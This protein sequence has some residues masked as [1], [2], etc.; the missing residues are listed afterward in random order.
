M[1]WRRLWNSV[2]LRRGLHSVPFNEFGVQAWWDS[3]DNNEIARRYNPLFKGSKINECSTV[4]SA[5]FDNTRQE[6]I[7]NNHVEAHRWIESSPIF[8]ALLTCER[9]GLLNVSRSS[10]S[11]H[12][13]NDLLGYLAQTCHFHRFTHSARLV[14]PTHS[15]GRYSCNTGLNTTWKEFIWISSSMF[16]VPSY[17]ESRLVEPKYRVTRRFFIPVIVSV[18]SQQLEAVQATQ[19]RRMRTQK[20]TRAII[21]NERQ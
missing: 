14:L 18:C 15:S 19:T 11:W 20:R 9:R 1:F 21:S 17:D 7:C 2:L 16:V 10:I 4:T 8:T 13:I 12:L 5:L 3:S 6:N